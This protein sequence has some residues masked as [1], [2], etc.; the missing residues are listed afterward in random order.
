MNRRPL[1][2]QPDMHVLPE[3]RGMLCYIRSWCNNLVTGIADA[4][5]DSTPV[6]AVT[7]Q[8]PKSLIGK[9][10][11]QEIDITGITLPITKH[12]YLVTEAGNVAQTV[13]EAFYIARVPAGLVQCSLICPKDV[14]VDSAEFDYSIK[15]SLPGYKPTTMGTLSV[16]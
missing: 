14:Q 13:K 11:F 10:A 16:T 8:V 6:I 4:Y 9:D 12:N 1:T 5:M 2:R 3:A 7:G 15:L